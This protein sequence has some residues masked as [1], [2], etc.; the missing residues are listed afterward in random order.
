MDSMLA[1]FRFTPFTIRDLIDIA[2]V[3]FIIYRALLLM[4]GTRGTQMT[5]GII[6]LLLFYWITR[7]YRL[8]SVQWLLSNLLTYIVFAIIVLYQ[9]EIRRGLAGIG[10]T[11]IWGHHR[12]RNN[13]GTLRSSDPASRDKTLFQQHHSRRDRRG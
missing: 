12:R 1:F 2:L 13:D 9:N 10:K 8:A 5:F 6:M 4:R 3:A 11:S 7:F